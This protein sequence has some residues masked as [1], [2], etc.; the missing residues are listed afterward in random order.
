MTWV[1]MNK[2]L[3]RLIAKP[4]KAMCKVNITS[5]AWLGTSEIAKYA[6]KIVAITCA[7]EIAAI[8]HTA[9]I[10]GTAC[11]N[12]IIANMRAAEMVAITHRN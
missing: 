2:Y 12:E 5:R 7:A 3:K 1:K 9:E 10:G 11:T 4:L 6:A 8:M